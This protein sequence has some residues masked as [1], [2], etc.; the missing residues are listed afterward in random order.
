MEINE[1]DIFDNAVN[2]IKSQLR[3]I[4]NALDKAKIEQDEMDKK[5]SADEAKEQEAERIA[6]NAQEH[7]QEMRA[8][9]EEELRSEG[10]DN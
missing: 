5:I 8:Q 4:E 2:N 9:Y 7:A 1:I 10:T 6:E 3:V